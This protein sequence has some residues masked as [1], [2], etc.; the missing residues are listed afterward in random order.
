MKEFM[1]IRSIIH[2]FI[3]ATKKQHPYTNKMKVT[4][5]YAR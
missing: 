2:M 4:S 5:Q 3:V 1:Y